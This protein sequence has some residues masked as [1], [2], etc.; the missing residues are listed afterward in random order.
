[1]S[2]LLEVRDLSIDF[3]TESQ[4]VHAVK[5]ASFSIQRGETLA[6]VGE[7]GAGKTATASSILQLL[8]YPPASHPSGSIR[9]EGQELIGAP[10]GVLRKVRGN[11]ISMIFQEPMT[12]LNPLHTIEKQ[13][14][15][16]LILHKN[17]T[18]EA[19]HRRTLELLHLVGLYEA[20]KR[21]CQKCCRPGVRHE[22]R[23]DRRDR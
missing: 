8:P 12:S 17:M 10:P 4:P 13:V 23:R 9:L 1:L 19:A 5:N 20:E 21:R 22:G 3:A 14:S 11:R 2:S 6:L 7:S 18:K 15:E 16:G